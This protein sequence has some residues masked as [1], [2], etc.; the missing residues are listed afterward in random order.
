MDSTR[1]I[2][3]TVEV[4]T[5]E[6]DQWHTTVPLPIHC[7]LMKSVTINDT[8]YLLGGCDKFSYPTKIVLSAPV[9]S[10]VERAKSPPTWLAAAFRSVWKTVKHT[11]LKQSTA[12]SLSRC[13]L[14]VGGQY[15][16]EQLSPAVHMFQPQTNSWVRMA[17]GD[18]PVAVCAVTAIQ[19][20]DNE[21][22][23]CGG[24]SRGLNDVFIGSITDS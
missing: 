13:L 17:S 21:L 18:L 5:D 2:C 14:A 3:A 7:Y 11:P 22:F 4:Y 9:T 12:A 20:P 24:Y 15:D 1:Q 19:L 6:T 23:I 8:C 10:L 16:H